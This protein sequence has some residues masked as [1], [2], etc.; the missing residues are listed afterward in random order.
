MNFLERYCT[1]TFCRTATMLEAARCRACASR[2]EAARCR[3]CASRLE[4]ARCRACASRLE[5]ARCRACASRL[6][7]P[8]LNFSQEVSTMH[9]AGIKFGLSHGLL[10]L[11]GAGVVL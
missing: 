10:E 1:L 2:L 9:P 5:A 4:A 6:Q 3:A 11:S 7:F 8:M